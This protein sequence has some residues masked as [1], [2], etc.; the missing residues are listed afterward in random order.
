MIQR[1]TAPMNAPAARIATAI[2]SVTTM[3]F[4]NELI[5][6]SI[7]T[8]RD[9]LDAPVGGEKKKRA[10]LHSYVPVQPEFPGLRIWKIS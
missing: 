1:T 4:N 9:I 5:L 8:Q 3:L 10:V 6:C 7:W 2:M